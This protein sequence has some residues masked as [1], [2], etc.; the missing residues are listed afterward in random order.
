MP[1]HVPCSELEDVYSECTSAQR[2]LT[3]RVNKYLRDTKQPLLQLQGNGDWDGVILQVI[4]ASNSMEKDLK[5]K[6]KRTGFTGTIRKS[7]DA[8]CRNAGAGK[9]L[10]SLIPGDLMIASAVSGS[11][12]IIFTALEEHGLYE[13]S[14][15]KALEALPS[16]LNTNE[17]YSGIATDDLEI[18]RRTARLYARV[19]EALEYILR[20]MMD[21]V[22]GMWNLYIQSVSL[23]QC[24]PLIHLIPPVSGAKQLF[25]PQRYA[26][27]LNDK[28]AEVRLAAEALDRWANTV[29]MESQKNMV[30]MLSGMHDQQAQTSRQVEGL[31]QTLN[32]L[33]SKID[34][35]N[36][37]E[38][39]TTITFNNIH[40]VLNEEWTREY[41]VIS[42]TE[43]TLMESLQGLIKITEP[44]KA[45]QDTKWR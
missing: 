1:A 4:K 6:K 12:K 36:E 21:N 40:L 10:L 25:R 39:C 11:F 35:G 7:F 14:V 20:W 27:D 37:L 24:T 3:E 31:Q 30:I 9:A 34:R 45:T 41:L 23:E 17:R 44:A 26:K 42:Q 2:N 18:H 28:M 8:L 29:I 19:C 13:E 33:E 38:R 22:F 32:L 5:S 16:I 43:H 15:F